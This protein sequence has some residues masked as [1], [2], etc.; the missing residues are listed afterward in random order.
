MKGGCPKYCNFTSAVPKINSFFPVK[1]V[2]FQAHLINHCIPD[3]QVILG[4]GDH[5]KLVLQQEVHLQRIL[6]KKKRWASQF[7]PSLPSLQAGEA[8]STQSCH[9]IIPPDCPTQS[10][11]PIIPPGR[12]KW[13]TN[14]SFGPFFSQCVRVKR[15]RG[16]ER[17]EEVESHGTT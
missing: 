1:I 5:K 15:G 17:E 9:P 13:G 2:F 14:T 16:G 4:Y 10:T 6:G 7:L 11:N 12:K 8:S 3:I